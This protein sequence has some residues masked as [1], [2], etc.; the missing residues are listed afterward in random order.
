VYPRMLSVVHH[1]QIIYA[2]VRMD[3]VDMV[4]LFAFFQGFDRRISNKPMD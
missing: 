4:Y 3:S 2:V 1:P